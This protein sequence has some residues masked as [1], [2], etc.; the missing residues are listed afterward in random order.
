MPAKPKPKK[1]AKT[2]KPAKPV[3]TGLTR[4][5]EPGSIWLTTNGSIVYAL[6][7]EDDGEWLFRVIKGG[8]GVKSI[9]GTDT[10]DENFLV[11]PDGKFGELKGD[12][13]DVTPQEREACAGLDLCLRIL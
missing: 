8:H 11:G 9:V 13:D 10:T 12:E 7:R 5:I 2:K 3:T 4:E 6:Y 1:P